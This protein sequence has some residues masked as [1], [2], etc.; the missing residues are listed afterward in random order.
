MFLKSLI[1]LKNTLSFRLTLW[2]AGIFTVS[3]LAIFIVLYVLLVSAIQRRTDESLLE[4]TEELSL[5]LATTGVDQIML[6]FSFES[7]LDGGDKIFFRLLKPNGEVVASSDMKFWKDVKVEK[8]VL[9]QMN[10]PTSRILKTETIKGMRYPVRIIYN[11]TGTGLVVQVAKSL[12]DDIRFFESLRYIFSS[13]FIVLLAISSVVGWFMA[14]RALLG[15]EKITETAIEISSG[16]LEK[17]VAESGRGEELDRLALAFNNMID[18]I[19]ALMKEMSDMTDNIAHDLRS[20]ITKIRGAAEVTLTTGKSLGEFQAMAS[21]TIEES[22]RLIGMINTMLDISEFEAGAGQFSVEKIDVPQLMESA[23]D[24]FQPVAENKEINL[25][26]NLHAD[27]YVQGDLQSLQRM[28]ANL[29][30]NALKYTPCGGSV[31]VACHCEN[32][33]VVISVSD[34]GIGISEEELPHIF[35]RF[36]RCDR[37]RSELG[38]GLGLSLAQAIAQ[39]HG[40]HIAATS[41]LSVGSTF[42]VSLPNASGSL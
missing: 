38:D 7:S 11:A 32:G 22:D 26:L 3:S 12:E 23:C 17:R 24:L 6:Y 9:A 8:N 18:R 1:R 2:Y 28:A 39:A 13:L 35:K 21:N 42:S 4:E 25:A 10:E 20:P 34:N 27:C 36:Y 14:R 33:R 30:D 5:L 29:L 19:Q 37:S 31:E 41:Q 40:G 16:S 15:V